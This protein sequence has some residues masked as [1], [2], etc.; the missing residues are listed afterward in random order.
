MGF[1]NEGMYIFWVKG[2]ESEVLVFIVGE[3]V[4]CLF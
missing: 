1:E 4:W 3:V 2:V